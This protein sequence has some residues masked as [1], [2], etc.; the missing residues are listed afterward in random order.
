MAIIPVYSKIKIISLALIHNGKGPINSLSEGG[1]YAEAAGDLYDL[2]YSSEIARGNWRF[3]VKTHE[4]A[5]LT[6]VT[7]QVDY[8]RYV[9]LLP[10]DYLKLERLDPALDYMIYQSKQLYSN[11]NGALVL[12]YHSLPDESSLPPHFAKYLSYRLAASLAY[13]ISRDKNLAKINT[14][15]ADKAYA[16]SQNID[17]YSVPYRRVRNIKYIYA[18]GTGVVY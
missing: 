9:Y 16:I 14:E 3:S 13:A 18:R 4:L 2:L 11:Y 8:W 15:E 6:G 17:G 10:A 7:P 12:E 5:L 1:D